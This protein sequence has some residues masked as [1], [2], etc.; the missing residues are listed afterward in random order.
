MLNFAEPFRITRTLENTNKEPDLGN[1][2]VPVV[3]LISTEI[4]Y[5]SIDSLY[6]TK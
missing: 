3:N 5:H 1:F 2:E 4:K 6:P